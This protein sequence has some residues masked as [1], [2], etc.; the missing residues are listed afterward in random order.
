MAEESQ[1][2]SEHGLPDRHLVRRVTTSILGIIFYG[3]ARR[4]PGVR[5]CFVWCGKLP[6]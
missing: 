5:T 3:P 6:V 2:D 1:D 4:E